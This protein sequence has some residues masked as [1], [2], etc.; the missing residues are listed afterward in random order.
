MSAKLI[1]QDKN[2]LT[3]QVKIP[4]RRQRKKPGNIKHQNWMNRL[5]P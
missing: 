5:M 3:I 1:S 2:G 4:L